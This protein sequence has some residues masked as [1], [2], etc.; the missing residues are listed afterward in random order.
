MQIQ[1]RAFGPIDIDQDQVLTLT[2]P[3]VGFPGHERFAVLD[4][5]PEA[6][7]KWFQAVDRA[8]LCFLI[9][10]PRYFFPDY[11]VELKA[12]A[13]ADLQIAEDTQAAVAVVLN[14]PGDPTQATAN[15]LA[16]VVF[17]TERKLARQVILD[18]TQ[19]GVRTPL[20]PEEKQVC[21]GP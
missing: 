7:F 13:L 11:R 10:D 15:L 2:E 14:V 4:P 12:A 19:Y 18:G 8:D 3:M 6:P 9:A 16:P 20:F 5:D 21:H 17:N 1:T